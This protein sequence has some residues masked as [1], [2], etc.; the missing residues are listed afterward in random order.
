MFISIVFEL[1]FGRKRKIVPAKSI[2][3]HTKEKGVKHFFFLIIIK[4]L[5]YLSVK[6]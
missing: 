4:L 1:G 3:L 5:F 6:C 2:Q